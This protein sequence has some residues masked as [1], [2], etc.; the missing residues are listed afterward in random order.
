MKRKNFKIIS[1]FLSIF[2]AVSVSVNAFE[3]YYHINETN[4]ILDGLSHACDHDSTDN[5]HDHHNDF[6]GRCCC[7]MTNSM[8]YVSDELS[9]VL[10]SIVH[11]IPKNCFF[12][13]LDIS[14]IDKPP[15]S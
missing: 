8:F 6:F 13:S 1:F 12:Y 4:T 2:M 11:N 3:P 14:L 10:F 5:H 7:N 9:F 15:R